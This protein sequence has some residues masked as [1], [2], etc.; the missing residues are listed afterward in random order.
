MSTET[1]L[2]HYD[3]R[4]SISKITR[5]NWL[6][7]RLQQ[8]GDFPMSSLQWI[9]EYQ[10]IWSYESYQIWSPTTVSNFD[11]ILGE[12]E[13]YMNFFFGKVSE[14]SSSFHFFSDLPS[15][16]KIVLKVLIRRLIW[17]FM[18]AKL[19][20]SD[21]ITK[22]KLC[23]REIPEKRL[24]KC[25]MAPARIIP[26][27]VIKRNR[28]KLKCSTFWSTNT[29]TKMLK[30]LNYFMAKTISK[31]FLLY[32]FSYTNSISNLNAPRLHIWAWILR[33][34]FF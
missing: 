23:I 4:N 24:N 1:Y 10:S 20:V 14:N 12:T 15:N 28:N 13:E 6:D 5:R 7:S 3:I 18:S 27:F 31:I 29:C 8:N 25:V 21:E 2:K 19:I 17:E 26:H 16:V 11:F 32:L 22:S 30:Y 34:N 33:W 9:F